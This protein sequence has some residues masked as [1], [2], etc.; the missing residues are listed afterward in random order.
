MVPGGGIEPPLRLERKRILSPL[1]LPIP[2][3]RL[4]RF[5]V[6]AQRPLG[7]P[8]P[9]RES[10]GFCGQRILHGHSPPISQAER[11]M[12]NFCPSGGRSPRGWRLDKRHPEFDIRP[13]DST[14]S[15]EI[16]WENFTPR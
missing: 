1:R 13:A 10:F 8:L 11:V 7:N 2:P 16:L 12:S 9:V 4:R 14:R 6:E 3:S 5:T 15:E